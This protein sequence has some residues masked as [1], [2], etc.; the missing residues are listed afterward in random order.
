M[1][2]KQQQRN[3]TKYIKEFVS[4]EIEW[5]CNLEN[6]TVYLFKKKQKN[7]SLISLVYTCF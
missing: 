1:A 7:F 4:Q 5:A 3:M 6:N 2:N